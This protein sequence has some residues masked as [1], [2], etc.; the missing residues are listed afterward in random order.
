MFF[1]GCDLLQKLSE[2]FGIPRCP[3]KSVWRKLMTEQ[4]CKGVVSWNVLCRVGRD[5]QF[6]NKVLQYTDLISRCC[7][8]WFMP[9]LVCMKY[10]FLWALFFVVFFWGCCFL[11][12]KLQLNVL[13]DKRKTWPS[14]ILWF[15]RRIYFGIVSA[16]DIVSRLEICEQGRYRGRCTARD[17]MESA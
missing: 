8:K 9:K 6:C 15:W 12:Y 13:Y 3:A 14:W 5:R 1:K 11:I 16:F 4:N 7:M 10:V 17:E 2:K